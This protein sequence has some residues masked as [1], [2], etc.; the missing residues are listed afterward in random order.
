VRR[1]IAI[2]AVA[3][4]M[5]TGCAR[6]ERPEG[7]V[8]RWLLALN[9]GQAG[10]PER[11]APVDVSL[12]VLPEYRDADP[13]E[14]DVIEVG[15]AFVGHCGSA[16]PPAE[17]CPVGTASAAVPFRVVGLDGTAFDLEAHLLDRGGGWRIEGLVDGPRNVPSSGGPP[18]SGAPAVGW[19]IAIAAAIALVI[20]GEGAMR[21]ARGSRG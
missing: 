19:L 20:F 21:L 3:L 5:P 17:S 4:L 6:T 14:F 8:E 9:Q 13:G 11:Y 1:A 16:L 10:E 12:Q 18:I 7:I 2:A 15:R